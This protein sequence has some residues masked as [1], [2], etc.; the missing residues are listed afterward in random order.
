MYAE[1]YDEAVESRYLSR[2]LRKLTAHDAFITG[3][4]AK[5][6]IN[7]MHE[8]SIISYQYAWPYKSEPIEKE[9]DYHMVGKIKPALKA[10]DQACSTPVRQFRWLAGC[11]AENS[12]D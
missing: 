11:R 4:D 7:S 2:N 5:R 1:T 12:A 6:L 10:L 8:D 9:I 3:K